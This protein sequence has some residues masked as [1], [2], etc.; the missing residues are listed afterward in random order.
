[1]H[2]SHVKFRLALS[3]LLAEAARSGRSHLEDSSRARWQRVKCA[4]WHSGSVGF[5]ALCQAFPEPGSKVQF[6][7]EYGD[8]RFRVEVIGLG[9]RAPKTRCPKILKTVGQAPPQ[10]PDPD[11][12]EE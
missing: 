4:A 3:V 8:W 2:R 10:Y 5:Q 7:F 9:E 1:M 12:M 11:E 6:L